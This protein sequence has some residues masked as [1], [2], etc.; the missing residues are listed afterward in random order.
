MTEQKIADGRLDRLV[1]FGLHTKRPAQSLLHDRMVQA[2]AR[3]RRRKA[4]VTLGFPDVD[5]L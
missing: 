1:H 3:A 2:I 5:R 4:R